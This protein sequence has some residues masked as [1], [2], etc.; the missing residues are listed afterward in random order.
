MKM[1]KLMLL[2]VISLTLVNCQKEENEII[3]D[4]QTPKTSSLVS[5]TPLIGLISRTTQNPTSLDNILDNS[6]CFSV[7]LPVTVIVNGNTIVVSTQANYQTV[8]N[9]INAFSNDDDIVNFVYPITIKFQDF[10]TRVLNNSTD[11]DNALEVCGED[12]G[13]NEIDC[14]AINYPIVVNVYD[15]NNQIANSIV[16]TSNTQLFNYII[17]LDSQT[18][19]T[20]VYP[21]SVTNSSGQSIVINSNSELE[22]FIDNSINDCDDSSVPSPTFI[23][24]L[25]SGTWRVSYFSEDGV[26]DTSNYLGYVFTF[27]SN[28]STQIVKNAVTTS[29]TWSNYMD[30]GDNKLNLTF[31]SSNLEELVE[32]WNVLEYSQTVIRLKH[33]SGGDGSIDYLYFTKN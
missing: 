28:F 18:I 31:G 13:F 19:S 7:Q 30:S 16:I 8:Q 17:N 10:S 6:S 9:A 33:I 12:D 14:I 5:N 23:S 3:D 21:I 26:D 4:S 20:I 25:T 29:G 1:K 15:V 2:F 27:N 22:N 24:I 11:L 32:D